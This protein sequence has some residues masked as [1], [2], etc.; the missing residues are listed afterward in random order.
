MVLRDDASRVV[1]GGVGF[2]N[3]WLVSVK[4]RED[5]VGGECCF[6]FVEC[7]LGFSG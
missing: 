6:E 4:V 5:W 7:L 3:D 2:N 1:V